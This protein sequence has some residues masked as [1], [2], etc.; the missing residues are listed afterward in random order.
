MR[1]RK[2][3][4]CL[5]TT[6]LLWTHV[7]DRAFGQSPELMEAFNSFRALYEQGKYAEA[8]PYAREALRLG[9]EEFGPDNPTTATLLNN[10]A[11]L[12]QALSH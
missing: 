6:L 4:L 3:I 5:A 11:S 1:A 2:T 12:Y 7:S 9:T 8:A 10:L